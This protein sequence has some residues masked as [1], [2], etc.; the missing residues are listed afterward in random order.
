MTLKIN[1][2]LIIKSTFIIIIAM[3]MFHQ[4]VF[5]GSSKG[6]SLSELKLNL[7]SDLASTDLTP[8]G[9]F[10]YSYSEI[11]N[12]TG[13]TTVRSVVVVEDYAFIANGTYGFSILD[14]SN[15]SDI[16]YVSRYRDG[17]TAICYDL[18]VSGDYVYLAYGIHGLVILDISNKGSPNV[19][20]R[21]N[22]FLIAGNESRAIDIDSSYAY[23][24]C[25]KQGL[26][27]VSI[28]VKTSPAPIGTGYQNGGFARDVKK[29]LDSGVNMAVLTFEKGV[30]SGLLT[31]D[32]S[33]PQAINLM[34][35]YST[36]LTGPHGLYVEFK[37]TRRFAYVADEAGLFI[38]GLFNPAQPSLLD[39]QLIY[40]L[41]DVYFG[42]LFNYT[43]VV[44]N[45]NGL[46]I[47]NT[48]FIQEN[49]KI[50]GVIGTYNDGGDAYG[51]TVAEEYC[52]VADGTTGLEIIGLD[53]DSDLLLDGDEVMVY[54]TDPDDD[55]TDGDGISDG[56]EILTY[57]TDPND[58]DSDDD[59]ILDGEEII[60]GVDG[61]I[62][63]VL[64]NDT[65]NDGLLDGDEVWGIYYN[66]SINRNATGYIFTNPL[67]S[68]T[69]NDI[70]L[71]GTE[72]FG[73]G[74]DP[75]YFDTD[76]DLMSDYY[77]VNNGLNATKNDAYE[78]LDND[79]L[80]NIEEF[81]RGTFAD[82]S[83]SDNDEL[84]DGEEVYGIYCPN[85]P[86]ANTTGYIVTNKPLQR[87]SDADGLSDGKEVKGIYSP[88]NL[89][90]N[91]TGYVFSN[92]LDADSDKDGIR[93]YFE[94][95]TWDT[96]PNAVD[97]D[98]DTMNDLW[99]TTYNNNGAGTNPIVDDAAV[100]IDLDGLTNLEEYTRKTNPIVADTDGDGMTD[101]WEVLYGFN[102][103]VK[104]A[105][106]DPDQD[107]LSNLE[108][109]LAG[110][111]PLLSDTDGDGMDD[112]W[113][114]N[115]HT[116]PLVDD[117]D[118][119][120]DE[121][122]LTNLEEYNANTD[123][124]DS[125]SDNDGLLDGEEVKTYGTNPNAWDTDGDGDSDKEEI[126]AGTDPLNPNSNLLRKSRTLALTIGFTTAIGLILFLG[127]FFVFFW[128]SRPEQK[129]LRYLSNQKAQGELSLS[130]KQISEYVDKKLN[131]GEVKQ[132]INEHSD[133]KKLTLDE[134][135][136]WLT[137]GEELTE[138]IYEF[139]E[140]LDILKEK[141][142]P[143]EKTIQELHENILYYKKA[144]SKLGF[145]ELKS[146][147][148]ILVTQTEDLLKQ[149]SSLTPLKAD[150]PIKEEK[151]EDTSTF[152]MPE[153]GSQKVVNETEDLEDIDEVDE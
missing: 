34:G 95:Y 38:F 137:N 123:P 79:G 114:V 88:D 113:E 119:D 14:I 44:S 140:K 89:G 133:S 72:Y 11:A 144:V 153:I 126:E 94:I 49:G 71:D 59:K 36:E 68:D 30:D 73:Y 148:E 122:G 13:S 149:K 117:A 50:D 108:E 102:P 101:G 138:K 145:G 128:Y 132:L 4:Q 39:S 45:T 124:D 29:V 120:M 15:K 23:L 6:E 111:N 54:G 51:I 90:A 77:E 96:N 8:A 58:P 142:N 26:M 16:T 110:T 81:N 70:L 37:G 112:W 3:C 115:R 7:D 105:N 86:Y 60:A 24:A 135:R 32:V 56:K 109:F 147:Y 84:S 106:N 53:N 46:S 85:N 40:N 129:M 141:S 134:N 91:T 104:N 97:S 82:L 69:D 116:N 31:V 121:D 64:N 136:V 83:D 20:G 33:N 146:D 75:T 125:D 66:E 1:K 100:D 131:R 12:W 92:P 22:S 28:V 93:D 127:G 57:K 52:Y 21:T 61:Y 63:Q 2:S 143:S 107:D 98:G 103:L 9:G 25:G 19:L 35:T 18:V 62:T 130:V 118:V 42:G 10:S 55:D 5:D 43:Y 76:L 27:I 87:D 47:L 80:I 139:Q 152:D 65:D 48:T 99:E 150:I 151:V 41:R 67:D 74:T 78:D 17:T